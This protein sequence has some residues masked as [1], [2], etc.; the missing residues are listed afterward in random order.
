MNF[1]FLK[2]NYMT[3]IKLLFIMIHL[4]SFWIIY[5]YSNIF[6]HSKFLL[7]IPPWLFLTFLNICILII[8]IQK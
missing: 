7:T 1:V 2:M 5:N 3:I 8:E 6:N 4:T